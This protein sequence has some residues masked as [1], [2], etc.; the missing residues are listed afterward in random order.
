[1]TSYKVTYTDYAGVER[2][3]IHYFN[4]SKTELQMLNARYGGDLDKVLARISMTEDKRETMEF[5]MDVFKTAYG[6]MDD[7]HI[8]FRKSEQIWDDFA[9]TPAFDKLFMQIMSTDKTSAEF[10]R[11]VLP[12]E[13]NDSAESGDAAAKIAELQ[14]ADV[15]V[16]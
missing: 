8:H 16:S 15:T 5:L 1:M 9:S 3:E 14:K 7:D 11:G 6:R 10:V 2:T 12:K 13:V 4:I